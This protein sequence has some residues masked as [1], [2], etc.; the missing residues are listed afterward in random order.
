MR[1]EDGKTFF[2][3]IGQYIP[4]MF[5]VHL[6]LLFKIN[7]DSMYCGIHTYKKIIVLCV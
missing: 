3:V 5:N 1:S 2:V 6:F 7:I 4:K